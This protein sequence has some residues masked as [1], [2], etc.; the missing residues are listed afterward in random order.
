MHDLSTPSVADRQYIAGSGFAI[1]HRNSGTEDLA[2]VD[3][4]RG[5]YYLDLVGHRDVLSGLARRYVH[6]AEIVICECLGGI[7]IREFDRNRPVA[8]F[9]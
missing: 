6:R 3:Q 8:M 4:T 5:I 2:V 9:P 7:S 1:A